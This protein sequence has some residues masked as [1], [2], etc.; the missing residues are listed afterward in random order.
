[1]GLEA[2]EPL[3]AAGKLCLLVSHPR[4]DPIGGAAGRGTP[5]EC[6]R[7]DLGHR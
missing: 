6:C 2:L 5:R 4:C 1:V 7:G 3:E